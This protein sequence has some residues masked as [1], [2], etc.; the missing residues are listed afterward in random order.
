M[1]LQLHII[2][3]PHTFNITIYLFYYIINCNYIAEL[4]LLMRTCIYYMSATHITFQ[5]II[6][7]LFIVW[8][9]FIANFAM[10]IIFMGALLFSTILLSTPFRTSLALVAIQ[11]IIHTGGDEGYFNLGDFHPILQYFI[12]FQTDNFS[13]PAGMLYKHKPL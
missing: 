6:C 4:M 12:T 9:S 10:K 8:L 2:S 5:S 13:E 7:S 11:P 3:E 1:K